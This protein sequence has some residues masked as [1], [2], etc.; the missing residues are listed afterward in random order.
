MNMKHLALTAVIM[1]AL[2]SLA[3]ASGS[4]NPQEPPNE[5]PGFPELPPDMS[6]LELP[7][8]DEEP[9]PAAAMRVVARIITDYS[10]EIET[11]MNTA[12]DKHVESAQSLLSD[13]KDRTGRPD[14]YSD[15]THSVNYEDSINTPDGAEGLISLGYERGFGNGVHV[16]GNFETK[17]SPE[18][19][20]TKWGMFIQRD[21]VQHPHTLGLMGAIT[22][23]WFD[24]SD[25]EMSRFDGN[26][27]AHYK[28]NADGPFGFYGDALV[29][30]ATN[31]AKFMFEDV[32]AS[33]IY[34]SDV[35]ILGAGIHFKFMEHWSGDLGVQETKAGADEATFEFEYDDL[36]QH[37][38]VS[39]EDRSNQIT[40]GSLK[41]ENGIFTNTI[42]G[43]CGKDDCSATMTPKV[44]FD[45]GIFIEGT[46]GE[47]SMST[48]AGYKLRM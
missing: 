17:I 21:F 25:G 3:V 26:V 29:S 44:Q 47:D 46:I 38:N 9:Q 30:K 40:R 1:A 39:I 11:H 41:Y 20:H 22:S 35:S 5:P 16:G 37:S 2:P 7:G 10:D 23:T 12:L 42:N 18:N 19:E 6:A 45:N 27:G 24:V 15:F 8:I 14:K 4:N 31:N 36:V 28:Y 34:G 33:S 13:M 32:R 43:S 48:K